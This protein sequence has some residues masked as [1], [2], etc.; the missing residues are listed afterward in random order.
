MIIKKA[1]LANIFRSLKEGHNMPLLSHFMYAGHAIFLDE[2]DYSNA[3][4]LKRIL[5]CFFAVSGL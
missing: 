1:C 2:W 5:R 3:I 4:T